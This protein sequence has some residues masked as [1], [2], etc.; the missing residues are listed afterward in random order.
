MSVCVCVCERERERLSR[1]HSCRSHLIFWV[2]NTSY[3]D[4]IFGISLLFSDSEQAKLAQ[5]L[6]A[7]LSDFLFGSS[8]FV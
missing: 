2:V 1:V 3:F 7:F 8:D 4:I 5:E 6:T